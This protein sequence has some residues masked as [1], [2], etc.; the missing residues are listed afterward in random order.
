M[1]YYSPMTTEQNTIDELWE[2]GQ[3]QYSPDFL[4]K[5]DADKMFAALSNLPWKQHI[6][7]MYGKKI[8]APRLFQWMGIPPQD[9]SYSGGTPTATGSLYGEGINPTPWTPEA[10]EIQQRVREATGFQFDSLNINYYRDEKDYL[11]FHIDKQNEGLWEFP[12]ASVSLGSE[13]DF[14]IQRYIIVN[15][16]KRK[17]V[18]EIY[19]QR[20]TTRRLIGERR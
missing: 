9:K 18:G 13:R 2:C 16:H 8:P 11:G 19:T 10:L 5:E 20:R 3:T 7:T 14:Q 17:H 1:T 4:T 15:H 6:I 12:I